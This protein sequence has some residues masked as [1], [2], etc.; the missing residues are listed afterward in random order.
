MRHLTLCSGATISGI[1]LHNGLQVTARLLPAEVPGLVFERAD[2]PGSPPLPADFRHVTRTVHATTLECNG[3]TVS[4]TE[5]LLAA[6]WTM[7]VTACRI[8]L[9]SGEVP[10]LDGSA[11]SWVEL[12]ENTGT[13]ELEVSTLRPIYRLTAPAWSGTGGVAVLGL[14]YDGLRLTCAVEYTVPQGRQTYD[15]DITPQIFAQEIA[16][17]RTFTL[18]SWLEPLRTQGLIRGG[19]LENALVLNADGPS[20]PYR[21]PDEL[22]RHKALDVLGDV[23]LMLAG[24]GGV[25]Q[26]HLIAIRAGHGP[27]RAWMEAAIAQGALVRESG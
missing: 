3:V 1:G 18:E 13:R 9:N 11:G 21:Y 12:I 5:H 15:S 23:A 16:P 2:L 26:A 10:I 14:P 6:L 22:A 8:V 27:H 4:T 24:D 25:L 19:S 7:G 17:A 20:V